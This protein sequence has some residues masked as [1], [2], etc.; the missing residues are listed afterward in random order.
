MS[1][2]LIAVMKHFMSAIKQTNFDKQFMSY[3]KV[4]FQVVFLTQTLEFHVKIDVCHGVLQPFVIL[5]TVKL[6]SA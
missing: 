4:H 3:F 1:V 6:I 2:Y 5:F